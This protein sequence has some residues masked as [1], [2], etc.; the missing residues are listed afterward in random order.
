[1]HT[2]CELGRRP[3]SGDSLG[4]VDL[5]DAAV[6]DASPDDARHRGYGIVKVGGNGFTGTAPDD[7]RHR[8]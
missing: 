1:M 7:A 6:E 2:G 3:G 8:G 5:E 4:G